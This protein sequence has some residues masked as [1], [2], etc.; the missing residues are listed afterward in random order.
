MSLCDP[1]IVNRL[2]YIINIFK[3]R[4]DAFSV[5]GSAAYS[6]PPENVIINMGLDVV[7]PT[8]V[9]AIAASATIM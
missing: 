5:T 1:E 9:E 7:R 4:P 8:A 2:F 6:L 3:Q